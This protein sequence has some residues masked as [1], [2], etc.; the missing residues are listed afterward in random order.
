VPIVD[1]LAALPLDLYAQDRS[2]SKIT[3]NMMGIG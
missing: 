1:E 2:L 3:V